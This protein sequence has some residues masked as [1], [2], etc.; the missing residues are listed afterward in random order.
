MKIFSLFFHNQLLLFMRSL[1]WPILCLVFTAQLQARSLTKR[2]LI[3]LYW[4]SF[5]LG[6]EKE[7]YNSFIL[8]TIPTNWQGN[9][10]NHLGLVSTGISGY[11]PCIPGVHPAIA[12][13]VPVGA[14]NAYVSF[15]VIV[16]LYMLVLWAMSHSEC[17]ACL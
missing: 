1:V 7:L 12:M 2:N 8:T 9:L 5:Q 15:S 16:G 17:C 3:G 10:Q 11:G 6:S 4:G 14:E 13:H